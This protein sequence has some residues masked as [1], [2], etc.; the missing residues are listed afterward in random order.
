MH[1]QTFDSWKEFQGVEMLV[2]KSFLD[3][4]GEFIKLYESRVLE[5]TLNIK[6]VNVSVNPLKGTLRGMHY[7][8]GTHIENK[9]IFCLSGAIFDVLLDLRKGSKTYLQALKL[10]LNSETEYGIF[11]PKGFAHGFQTVA[12]DTT[13]V[14]F[15]SED[16]ISSEQGRICPIS[17]QLKQIWPEKITSISEADKTAQNIYYGMSIL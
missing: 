13:L 15:H 12:D 14:Y 1:I 7:Q 2:K 16:Y 17:D 11:I 3:E 10:E 8:R 5:K 6:Q 4:R 9:A